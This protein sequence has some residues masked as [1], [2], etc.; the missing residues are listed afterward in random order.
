VTGINPVQAGTESLPLQ[1]QK[2]TGYLPSPQGTC[3]VQR[4]LGGLCVGIFTTI[5]ITVR[6]NLKN[7]GNCGNAE[8]SLIRTGFTSSWPK[9]S[10]CEVFHY[11][12]FSLFD[13]W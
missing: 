10:N 1:R 2:S 7:D 13:D 5:H 11:Y 9:S 8:S 12:H 3:F 6:G 4:K